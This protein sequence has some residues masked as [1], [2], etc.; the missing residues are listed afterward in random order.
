MSSVF[1]LLNFF[2]MKYIIAAI[3][4]T[5][6]MHPNTIPIISPIDNLLLAII[7]SS[8]YGYGYVLFELFYTVG[9]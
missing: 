2:T 3:K 6:A 9:L 4:I 7:L 5:I 1:Y 8:G